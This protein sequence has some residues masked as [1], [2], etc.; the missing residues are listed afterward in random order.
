MKSL[1]PFLVCLGMLAAWDCTLAA[2][3]LTF[4]KL[5]GRWTQTPTGYFLGSDHGSVAIND[6][7]IAAGAQ[8]AD[9]QATNQGAVQIFN[10]L[11]GAGCG[12]CCLPP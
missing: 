12:N 3:N 1:A 11:T 2:P 7:W 5:H 6:K 9:E 8:T 4:Q 10:A